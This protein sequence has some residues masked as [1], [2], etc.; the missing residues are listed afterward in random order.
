MIARAMA[1]A[2]ATLVAR[3]TGTSIGSG[4]APG[5][6]RLLDRLGTMMKGTI[7]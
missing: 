2:D 4:M 5:L 1:E 6:L 3:M 7:R